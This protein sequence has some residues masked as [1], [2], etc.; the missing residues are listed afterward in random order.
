[1]SEALPRFEEILDLV[2]SYHPECDE[3]LLRRAYVYSAMA[4]RGQVRVSGEPYLIH[5]L[6]VAR[7]LAEMHL[8]EVA[9]AAGLLH[10]LLEDTFVTEEEL[11]AQFGPQ[12][13]KIVTALTKI[14]TMEQ[15]YAAREAAQAENVRRMLLASIED[16]RVILVKLA[17]RLHNM[18]TLHFLPEASRRRIARETLEIYAPIAHRLGIGRMKAELEDL[19][20]A[21]S[22]PEEHAQLVEQLR[23]REAA[24]RA[25]IDQI[26]GIL[27]RVLEENDI[28][29]EIRGR[30]KHLYSIWTKLKRQGISLDRVYDFLAFRIIVETVQQC[31]GALGLIHQLWRPVPGRIKDYIAMPKPNAYQSLHTSVMGPE[32]QP[33]EVQIRTYDMDQIA[34]SGIAA[35]WMYKAG[36]AA[37]PEPER[38][39]W[40]RGLVEGQQD[41][42]RDFL[43][44]LKLDLYP[45]E[46]YTFSPKGEVFAFPR[47]ATAI[48]YA[49]RVH[50]ELGHRCVGARINGRLV[51]LR[52]RLENGDIVEI[53]TSPTQ[54]P[55]RDW[56]DI[57][58]TAR[59]RNKIRA[60]LNRGEKE[61]AVEM[62]QRLLERECRRLRLPVKLLRDVPQLTKMAMEHGFAKTEDFVAAIG[63]GR[64]GAREV[65]LPLARRPDE[66]HPPAPKAPPPVVTESVI[67]VKGQRDLLTFRARCCNPLPG[68]EICG[69]VTRGRGVAIHAATCH[70][71]RRLR[72]ATDRLV[73]VEWGPTQGASYAVPLNVSFEDRPGMLAAITQAVTGEE[74]NIRSCQMAA[75]DRRRGAA[76]LIIDI[77]GREHLA[78]VFGA[79][80]QVPGVTGVASGPSVFSRRSEF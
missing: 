57:A 1:M 39:N 61:H 77:Q 68:D 76:D 30:I 38:A 58:A 32:G 54:V 13:T 72:A 75:H 70:N 33:F 21:H 6:E 22:H 40:L 78:R 19:A 41:N 35:H 29:A 4:H 56:L 50:T 42:P 80:R 16:V 31:Y 14:T 37:E 71:L 60:W 51:P 36:R 63:F 44:S 64:L 55:S 10:D 26:R 17:D 24:A 28:Q 48:D 23:Q 5:P 53:M 43:D 69:Y 8:D 34:E 18:R 66:L 11:E 79:L 12:I 46:V 52:T 65:L 15:S 73:K 3:V 49:Y 74:A 67:T 2:A 59:A 25:L 20:F 47:G 62:G 9:I 27:G 45:E 7:I